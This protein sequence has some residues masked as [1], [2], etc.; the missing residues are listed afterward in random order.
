MGE[1]VSDQNTIYPINRLVVAVIHEQDIEI[2]YASLTQLGLNIT[3]LP[4][5][6]G[7][8]GQRSATLLIGLNQ[9]Q[10]ADMLQVIR[11]TC[12]SRV[13][14]VTLPVEGSPLPIPTPT[15]ITVGGATL[16]AFEVEHFEEF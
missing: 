15:P 4:S 6:G 7:F 11:Q 12:R 2:T 3:R 8:L 13:E 16:F 10:E 9:A 5:S 1:T 14:Y